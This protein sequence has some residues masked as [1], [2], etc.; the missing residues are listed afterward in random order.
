[1][2]R[3]RLSRVI[4]VG[5]WVAAAAHGP[6]PASADPAGERRPSPPASCAP[7]ARVEGDGEIARQVRLELATLGVRS[8][9]IPP[10]CPAVDVSLS[11]M[12]DRVGVELRDPSGRRAQLV[13][14][15]AH[16]AATWIESW[17]HPELRA[18]LLVA[19]VFAPAAP[20]EPIDLSARA[21]AETKAPA[22]GE[23]AYRGVQLAAA[24]ER[25]HASD[26]S[27]WRSVSLSGCA[28][29]GRLCPGLLARLADN[30]DFVPELGGKL[31][32]VTVDLLASLGA[33]IA[34]GRMELAP[35]FAIG[36]GV[37]R[38]TDVPCGDDRVDDDGTTCQ[39][40]YPVVTTLGPRA[41]FGLSGTFPIASRVSL[42]IAGSLAFAPMA[43][44]RLV[45]SAEPN[46][47][48]SVPGDPD[49][50][51]DDGNDPA[52]GENG[53]LPAERPGEPDHYTRI[54]VGLALELP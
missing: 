32:R 51:A 44:S 31:D 37:L 13:V 9:H 36:L 18:P 50:P 27:D 35:S 53:D 7:A 11:A 49:R 6:R 8:S 29:L 52:T 25:L 28:R 45:P 17:V 54:G 23:V 42:I 43:Y 12:G 38:T 22:A 19:P 40:H 15:N 21:G 39:P 5:S 16:V 1:M 20:I 3:G 33:P 10:V 46:P 26:G 24:A 4:L 30:R 34:I 47:D 48:G 2:E 14:T 41:E